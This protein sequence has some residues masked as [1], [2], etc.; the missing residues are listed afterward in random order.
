MP[1]PGNVNALFTVKLVLTF[2]VAATIAVIAATAGYIYVDDP[3]KN[4][5]LFFVA[6]IAAAG[7]LGASLYTARILQFTVDTQAK[8][9]TDL[10]EKEAK[11]EKQLLEDAAARYGA[12]WVDP[13]MYHMR[14]EC[15]GIIDKRNTPDQVKKILQENENQAT[16]IRNALNFL[17]DMALSVNRGRCDEGIARDLFCGIVLNIWHATGPWVVAERVRLGRTQAYVQLENLFNRWR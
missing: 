8:S 14:K 16:N 9:A 3:Y 1:E 10:A 11:I 7:Q 4:A 13:A 2:G 17:E 6:S 5:M 12:R 15:I